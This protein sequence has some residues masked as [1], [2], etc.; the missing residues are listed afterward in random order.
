[1]YT[2]LHYLFYVLNY[3]YIN[4]YAAEFT[5][6]IIETQ[7]LNSKFYYIA[8]YLVFILYNLH[9]QKYIYFS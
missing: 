9:I 5:T 2:Y 6:K 1:M 3:N 7:I 8:M 4:V